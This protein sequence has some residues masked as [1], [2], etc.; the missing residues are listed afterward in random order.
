MTELEERLR[1]S[2]GE[3]V[4]K[5]ILERLQTLEGF[6]AEEARDGLPPAAFQRNETIGQ[7]ILAARAVIIAYPANS[8]R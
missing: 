7:A 5:E 6:L 2:S 8:A 4:R 3:D 1:S